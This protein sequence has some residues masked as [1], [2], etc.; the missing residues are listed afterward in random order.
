MDNENINKG[1]IVKCDSFGKVTEVKKNDLVELE[2]GEPLSK[3]VDISSLSKLLS[4]LSDL[5]KEESAIG[6]EVNF[7]TGNKFSNLYLAGLKEKNDLIIIGATDVVETRKYYNNL[8]VMNNYQQNQLREALKENVK[9]KESLK[10]LESFDEMTK[11]NNEM[12]NLQRELARKNRTLNELNETLESKN[13]ELD[14]FAN[15][16]SHD[17]KAPLHKI[18][19]LFQIINA[20]YE[21]EFNDEMKELFGMVTDS[22]VKM[23]TL[24]ND[25]LEYSKAGKSDVAI[26]NFKVADL[27]NESI[28]MIDLAQE[29]NF[30]IPDDLPEI[31][32]SYIQLSQVITNL[33]SN[34][35]KYHD[36]PT[37]NIE[38]SVE[39]INNT[40][41][42]FS[43]KDDGP[44]IPEKYHEKVFEPFETVHGQNRDDSTGVGLAIVKKLVEQNQ[45]NIGLNSEVGKGTTFWFTWP[46]APMH[47]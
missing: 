47:K 23:D 7:K 15:I 13:Q 35:I 16:V 38:V 27:L 39:R 2:V 22:A 32:G 37:G 33:L 4:F 31:S 29:Y 24:I 19:G 3:V 9:V 42:Q 43:V 18:R 11:I 41:Y 20:K 21:D 46:K 8:M 5:N 25:I 6:W 17:L 10:Q 34:A 1:F 12:A 28:S 14:R 36:R 26:T 30:I 40:Y 44:G 45:G